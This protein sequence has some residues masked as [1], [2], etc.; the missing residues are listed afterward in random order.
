MNTSPMHNDDLHAILTRVTTG[1]RQVIRDAKKELQQWWRKTRGL[2][3]ERCDRDIKETY[4]PF[5]DRFQTF[6]SSMHQAAFIETL[7]IPF[8]ALG[9][10]HFD[11]FVPFVLQTVQHPSGAV[12]RALVH[13]SDWLVMS[14]IPLFEKQSHTPEGRVEVRKNQ[15]RFTAFVFAVEQLLGKYAKPEWERY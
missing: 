1:D 7:W 13:V 15:E 8:F 12:R 3:R 6:D 4:F 5:L 2:E 9:N 14:L 10:E 11:A